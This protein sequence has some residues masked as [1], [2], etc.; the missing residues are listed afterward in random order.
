V[1][2]GQPNFS[3]H[4]FQNETFKFYILGISG[5]TNDAIMKITFGNSAKSFRY[6]A[7]CRSRSW[8]PNSAEIITNKYLYKI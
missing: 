7:V 1:A 4:F 5:S 6:S 3:V 2:D 8:F